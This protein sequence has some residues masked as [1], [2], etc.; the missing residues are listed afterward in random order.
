MVRLGRVCLTTLLFKGHNL[1]LP[2]GCAVNL[3][4]TTNKQG[5]HHPHQPSVHD[6]KPVASEDGKHRLRRNAS[7]CILLLVCCSNYTGCMSLVHLH[8]CK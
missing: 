4:K 1:L 5:K 3:K 6:R 2:V 8:Y 7:T